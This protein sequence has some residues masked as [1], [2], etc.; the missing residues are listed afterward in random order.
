MRVYR[1]GMAAILPMV[2]VSLASAQVLVV[3]GKGADLADI[4]GT[5]TLVTVVLKGSS[6]MD[7]NLK[8]ESLANG[9]LGVRT[10]SGQLSHYR[11]SDIQ[12]VR[13]QGEV[14]TVKRLESTIDRGMTSDQ[15][16]VVARAAEQ[17]YAL[18]KGSTGD[19]GLRMAAAQVVAVSGT[20]DQK[21]EALEYLNGLA[22]GNDLRTALE[23]AR[24]LVMAGSPPVTSEM[25]A[26]GLSSGDRQVRASAALLAGLTGDPSGKSQMFKMLRDRASDFA[27][28]AIRGLAWLGDRE[29]IPTLLTLITER[30]E[31]KANAAADALILLGGDEIVEQMKL[32]LPD[33]EGRARFRVVRVLHALG[34]PLGSKLMQEEMLEIPSLSFE[35]AIILA[36]QGDL[37]AMQVLRERLAQ[38][39]DAYEEVLF[40]RAEAT[41]ALIEAGDRTNIGEFQE[42]LR[43]GI[44]S[45]SLRVLQLISQ[46]TVKSLLPVTQPAIESGDPA[47]SLAGCQAAIALTNPEYRTRLKKVNP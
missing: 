38:K 14:M 25:I 20:E 11:V 41:A 39:Y 19:Q 42:L 2:L 31:E 47:I 10:Q 28:P 30:S 15:K 4:A 9:I 6:A 32:K 34:D 43:A 5:D 24:N 37:K 44:P 45:V 13:V 7:S 16:Q 35:T 36:Q 17:A 1:K 46:L 23:A 27:V 33:V 29:A 18:F 8:V 40:H 21:A 12:E 22:S 3:G 26:Q